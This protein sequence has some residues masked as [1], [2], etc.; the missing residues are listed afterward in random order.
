M[1]QA[2]I[3][4]PVGG[5]IDI[6]EATSNPFIN[7][8]FGSYRFVNFQG[9]LLPYFVVGDTL[10]TCRRWGKKCGENKQILPG[11]I[12]PTLGGPAI[13]YS[14]NYHTFGLEWNQTHLV[15]SVNG[16]SYHVKSSSEVPIPQNPFYFI[17][18]TAVA[19]YLPP[20]PN[21]KFPANH[22]ID[23]VR[24]YQHKQEI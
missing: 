10:N 4:W 23:F 2:D 12:Y 8:I 15:F 6:M 5:E 7:A 3:C 16:T 18:N 19:W 22:V 13:H 20:G 11:S 14:E 17:L 24:V 21:A 1:P 9:D